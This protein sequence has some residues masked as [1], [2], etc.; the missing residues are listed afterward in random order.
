W[1][2]C[3]CTD[4]SSSRAPSA[5]HRYADG[6][7][8]ADIKVSIGRVLG[9]FGLAVLM[10]VPQNR[11]AQLPSVQAFFRPLMEFAFPR[12]LPV[13]VAFKSP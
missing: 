2:Q 8:F 6:S 5:R 13:A 1:T 11:S 9:G 3:S 7:L 4:A 12:Y 10:A